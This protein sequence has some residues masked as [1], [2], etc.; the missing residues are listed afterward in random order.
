LTILDGNAPN[1]HSLGS[2]YSIC[3]MLV[4][5]STDFCHGLLVV[6]NNFFFISR[7]LLTSCNNM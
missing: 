3:N 5:G 7:R 2:K 6:A 4:G 1:D